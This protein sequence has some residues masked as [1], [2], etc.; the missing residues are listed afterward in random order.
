MEY[1]YLEAGLKG[2]KSTGSEFH[3]KLFPT[4]VLGWRG[5]WL[6]GNDYDNDSN[7]YNSISKYN[8]YDDYKW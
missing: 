2:G 5:P 1:F 8:G 7:Y 3:I 4:A 6:L